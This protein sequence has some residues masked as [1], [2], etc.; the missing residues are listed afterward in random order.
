MAAHAD[1]YDYTFGSDARAF[2]M[3]GAGLALTRNQQTAERRFNPASLAFTPKGF[4]FYVPSVSFRADGGV[5][6]GKAYDYLFNLANPS[7]AGD[8]VRRFATEDSVFGASANIGFRIG[9]LEVLADGVGKGRLLPN[10][11]LRNWAQSG[12]NPANVPADAQADLLAAG[13]VSLPSI[14]YAV[15]LPMGGKRDVPGSGYDASVGLRVRFVQTY[16]ARYFANQAVVQNGLQGI[17][18]PEMQGK[19]Y[20]RDTGV[21]ADIGFLFRPRAGKGLNAAL[22]VNNVVKPSSSFT[23]DNSG[24]AQYQGRVGN[25]TEFNLLQT[26]ASAGVGYEIGGLSLAA[27]IADFSGAT[28]PLDFRLGG[29]QKLGKIVALRGGYSSATGV[30]FG[31]GA[32]GFDI[33]F[34]ERLP[35]EVNKSIRF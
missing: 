25:N 33:A 27:D 4:D 10:A 13:Y 22:V 1:D 6:T 21:S 24:L 5:S 26:T 3:G 18:A 9:A 8:L 30:S 28:R 19:D 23:A 20:L 31:L 7:D 34:A 32:F 15:K 35:L 11:S 17:K 12:S 2:A 14:A 29:E 16:Y